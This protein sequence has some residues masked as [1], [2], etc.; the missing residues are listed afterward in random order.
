M[1]QKN[2]TKPKTKAKQKLINLLEKINKLGKK[3]IMTNRKILINAKRCFFSLFNS[4]DDKLIKK[5]N[6]LQGMNGLDNGNK[7]HKNLESLI[8][9]R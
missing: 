1:T 3:C 2:S 7:N 4:N 8:L 9:Y 6:E 5:M